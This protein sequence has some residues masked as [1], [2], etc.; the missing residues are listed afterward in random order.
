MKRQVIGIFALALAVRLLASGLRLVHGLS[1]PPLLELEIYN[2]YNIIY[3]TQLHYLSEGYL[4]YQGFAYNYPPLFLYALYPFYALGGANLAWL[5]IVLSDAGS[6]VLIYLILQDYADESIAVGAALVY[7]LS[8]FMVLYEGY[9]WFSS[10]PMVFFVL[11]SF[12][13]LQLRKMPWA[14]VCFG[15][16]VLFKQD[17]LFLSPG[18]LA[19]LWYARPRQVVKWAS[20]SALVVLAGCAPFLIIAPSQFLTYTTFS[21]VRAIGVPYV[22]PIINL[23]ASSLTTAASVAPGTCATFTFAS[24]TEICATVPTSLFAT[25][26]YELYSILSLAS[27]LIVPPL[28]VLVG[29]ALYGVRKKRGFA[30]LLGAYCT[31]VIFV[32]FA[33]SIYHPAFYRYYLLS[34]YSLLLAASWKR[35]LLSIPLVVMLVS[36]V[37]PSGIFQ[38]MLPLLALLGMVMVLDLDKGYSSFEGGEPR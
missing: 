38:E 27:S 28:A 13:L 6:A 22:P 20:A 37:T 5:P 9:L 8:P 30:F 23:P 11:L 12:R 32:V 21:V 26:L 29:I 3:V 31:S 19:A 24:V 15:I 4:P 36:L 14:A 35:S 7:A 10:E 16:A 25:A 17:A 34:S 2:D 1:S 18:Y 33:T